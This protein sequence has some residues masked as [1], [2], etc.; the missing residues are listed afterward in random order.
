MTSQDHLTQSYD[1]AAS[2]W[3]T[4][5]EGLGYAAAYRWMIAACGLRTQHAHAIDVGCGTGDFSRALIEVAGPPKCLTLLDPAEQM[6][7]TATR[8]L[9]HIAPD[10]KPV[11]A[12]L[13]DAVKHPH[14]I[15]LCAHVIEHF[16]DPCAALALL[17]TQ[18]APDGKLLLIVSKPHWCN[19]IIWVRWRHR[20]I[21][22]TR[23][24]EYF[25]QTGLSCE[26]D[27]PFL[28][29][30]PSRSSHAYLVTHQRKTPQ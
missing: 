3:R 6:V 14:D 25:A 5:I 15:I 28:A 27:A 2:Q 12:G 10:L 17:G 21:R 26:W 16:S 30:P 1:I 8:S 7:A 20:M 4:K 23:M 24:L 19:W 9:T 18:L 22:P 13:E 29:G 11:V